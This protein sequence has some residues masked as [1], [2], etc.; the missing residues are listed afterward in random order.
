VLVSI[1]CSAEKMFC[2]RHSTETSCT[3]S[4]GNGSLSG[5]CSW[6]RLTYL[7]NNNDNDDDDDRKKNT[8]SV[9][10]SYY[11]TCSADLATCPDHSCDELE[12]IVPALCPQDC[13]STSVTYPSSF[14][15]FSKQQRAKRPLICCQNTYKIQYNTEKTKHKD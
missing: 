8:S 13:I 5:F 4:R 1:R 9:I 10:S 3:S 6:R 15:H 2:A 12:M 11:E 7:H 14:I